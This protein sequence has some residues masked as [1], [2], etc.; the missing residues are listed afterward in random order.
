MLFQLDNT[1]ENGPLIQH[2]I[3]TNMHTMLESTLI[4]LKHE[5]CI[6]LLSFDFDYFKLLKPLNIPVKCFDRPDFH[7]HLL[8]QETVFTFANSTRDIS[9]LV[10]NIDALDLGSS[11]LLKRLVR[12]KVPFDGVIVLY[13][14]N[15]TLLGR[16]LLDDCNEIMS[17]VSAAFNVD[18]EYICYVRPINADTK[19]VRTL[20]EEHNQDIL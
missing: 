5:P 18:D 7:H 9:A 10:V 16:V 14:S 15:Q 8:T 1:R 4:Q 6:H 3:D 17:L 20:L 12:D 11:W 2:D 19:R 13:G